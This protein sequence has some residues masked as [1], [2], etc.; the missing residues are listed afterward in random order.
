MKKIKLSRGMYALISDEDYDFVSQWKWCLKPGR[1]TFYAQRSIG[2]YD[3]EG[4]RRTKTVTLHKAI[5]QATDSEVH[6]DHRDGNGLNN[7]RFN[8]RTATRTQNKVNSNRARTSKSPK[9]SIYRGVGVR[10]KLFRVAF[11][12]RGKIVY[13][14]S[15]TS[16][17]DAGRKYNELAT[18]YF[19]EFAILNHI[20]EVSAAILTTII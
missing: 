1:N 12:Y 2:Y 9:R 15:F 20:N 14:R 7:Q 3:K 8:L 10:D 19:K 11:R 13:Y 5:L 4:K 17:H 16:E 18:K 6:I